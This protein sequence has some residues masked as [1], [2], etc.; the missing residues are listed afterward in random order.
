MKQKKLI[1]ILSAVCLVCVVGMILALALG[2]KTV[3]RFD[4]PPFEVSA[5]AGVPENVPNTS[6]GAL[7]TTA[8]SLSVCGQPTVID[9]TVQLWLTNPSDN[10]VLLKVRILDTEGNLL[11]ESGLLRP[12][13]YVQG[14]TLSTPITEDTDAVLLIM[15]YEPETYHSAGNIKLQTTFVVEKE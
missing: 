8:Y 12:G 15:A 14:V 11:G 2:R 7:N 9:G 6:Y 13:E 1:V 3:V 10:K 4:P 5:M